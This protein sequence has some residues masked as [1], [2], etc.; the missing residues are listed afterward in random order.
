MIGFNSKKA[1][2]PFA[3]EERVREGRLELALLRGVLDNLKPNRL[4]MPIFAAAICLMFA[5]WVKPATLCLWYGLVLASLLPQLLVS[6]M[7]PAGNPPPPEADRWLK[8]AA[9]A[10]LLHVVCWTSLGWL[11]WVPGNDFN[12]LLIQLVLATTLT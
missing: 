8:L 5:P 3:Q 6:R 7:L 2:A 4:M 11:L 10:N 12:H 9:I 1:A